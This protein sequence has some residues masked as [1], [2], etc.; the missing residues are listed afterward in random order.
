MQSLTPVID[1]PELLDERKERIIFCIQYMKSN[2]FEILDILTEISTY[3][4]AEKEF[5]CS[6]LALENAIDEVTQNQPPT[7]DRMSVFM[8]SNVVLYSYIL[9]LI[10]PSLYVKHIEF[11]GSSLV[12]DQVRKLHELFEKV[13]QLPIE[14]MEYSY[15]K[16]IKESALKANVVLFTGTYQ[17][18]ESIKFQL[19][20]DQLFVFFG[21]GVNPFIITESAD[22]EKAARDLVDVRMFNTGQDCMGP[23]VVYVS[24]Q[25][26][27]LFIQ[28]LKRELSNL[29][30]GDNSDE[31]AD[32]GSI[33]YTSTLES[34]ARYLNQ[35][36]NYIIHGGNINYKDKVIEPTILV[37]SLE[38]KLK[39]DEFFSPIFNIVSYEKLEG[40]K[41][42]LNTGYFLERAMGATVYGEGQH[43]L[44]TFLKRKHTVSV[45]QTL[46]DIEDGNT[47]FGGY[48]PMANYIYYEGELFIKPLLLSLVCRQHLKKRGGKWDK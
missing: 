27:P 44:I 38:E 13:H 7:I 31:R 39:I 1:S 20:K 4:T 35:N 15:R 34:I 33:H 5:N 21:Q 32:Y 25:I 10:I 43:E 30:F 19:S 41:E 14:L 29:K 48:G 36:S 2:K 3:Q 22:L 8:P 18:A 9:Y 26:K 24:E 46:F 40:I 45:N 37:S 42:V 16:Y 11:R 28:L 17:N 6:L 12:I 47:A 23:D